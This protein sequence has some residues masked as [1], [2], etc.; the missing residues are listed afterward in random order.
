MK[1]IWLLSILVVLIVVYIIIPSSKTEEILKEETLEDKIYISV[2]NKNGDIN[3]LEL[4]EYI[5]GVV[6]A[7]MPA[8]F[9]MEALKAQVIA[10]RSYAMCKI[11]NSKNSY[12]VTTDVTTQNYITIDEM[13]DKWK[14]DYMLYYNK[15]ADAVNSTNNLVMKQEE[16]II[17]SYYF[18]ISN[19]STI[20]SEYVFGESEDFIHSVDSSWD[21]DVN[22]YEVSTTI[23]KDE[24]CNKLKLECDTI[25]VNDINRYETNHINFITVNNTTFAGTD[26]RHSLNLRSTDLDIAVTNNDVIITTRGYGHGVG[27]SQYGAHEMAKEGFTYE[28]ILTHYYK[29]ITISKI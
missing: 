26:F 13:K 24:F 16:E 28:E 17:C 4:E 23:S 11:N 27:M 19:G 2:L 12:D 1:N 7:E 15:I 21:K 25:K 9:N 29:N 14:D 18:A 22:K 20:E 10:S 6:A 3:K 8:S 5:I